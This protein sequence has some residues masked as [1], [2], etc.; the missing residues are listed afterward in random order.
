MNFDKKIV[1]DTGTLLSA[2]FRID[3]VPSQAYLK[4]L[5]EFTVC[6][7]KATL[8]E[9]ETVIQRDKFSRYLDL[10][11]RLAFL[12]LYRKNSVLHPV[13][14]TV[15]DC[16]DAKDN[17]FLELALSINADIIVSSDPDLQI[18]NPY[19]NIPILKPVEFLN[20]HR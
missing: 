18:L 2:S 15:F 7:S 17:M 5:R 3:S 8:A 19:R 1:I 20:L 9:L 14:K 12:E 13:T 11:G 10:D 16:R 4:A 6:V